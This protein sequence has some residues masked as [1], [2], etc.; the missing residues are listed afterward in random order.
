MSFYARFA[1]HYEAVFPFQEE[2]Y[3][4]L[5]GSFPPGTGR[6]LDAGCGTGHY[7][8]RLAAD[9]FLAIGIDLDPEMIRVATARYP[10]AEFHRMDI[11]D[12]GSLP[13]GLDAAFCIGNTAAHLAPAESVRLAA[14]IRGVLAPGGVWIV[15][16]V[17]WDFILGRAAFQFPP[18]VM[19]GAG[20]TFHR[21]YRDISEAGLSF[22]TRLT[23]GEQTLFEGKIRLYPCRSSDYIRL[24]EGQGFR[25]R[26][27]FGNFTRAPFRP[28]VYS[29]SVFVFEKI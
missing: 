12:A 13:P 21:E 28:E 27:H 15:Q 9:G 6:I 10:A 22:L 18:K 4:F 1:D 24:H 14:G 5:R 8:G 23:A 25:L 17:N 29:G 7:C 20:V 3:A 16:V 2:T 11:L 26:G 19:A